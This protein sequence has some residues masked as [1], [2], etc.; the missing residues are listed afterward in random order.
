MRFGTASLLGLSPLSLTA[1]A[2]RRRRRV[3]LSAAIRWSGSRKCGSATAVV[4]VTPPREWNQHVGH[5][6]RRY[7]RRSRTG[8]RTGP[9]STHQL[10]HRAEGRQGAGPAAQPRR[11]AGAQIPVQ[12]DRARNRGDDRKPVPGPRRDGRFQDDRRSRRDPS[13]APTASSMISSISTA[14][15]SRRRGRAVGAVDRRAALPDPARCGAVA[16]FRRVAP[17]FRS[18]RQLGARR[19]SRD[20]IGRGRR[21]GLAGQRRDLARLLI[22]G[23]VIRAAADGWP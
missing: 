15:K 17:R 5:P 10:R 3:R 9:I 4:A 1:C 6:V 14:T 12:H 22:G 8:P 20:R 16:L 2:A 7:P 23:G 11:P 13:S 19:S 18:D 21:L